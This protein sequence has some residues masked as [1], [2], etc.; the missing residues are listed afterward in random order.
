MQ[1]LAINILLILSSMPVEYVPLMIE[2]KARTEGKRTIPALIKAKFVGDHL[3]R[4]KREGH[5]H[6]EIP[7]TGRKLPAH[8]RSGAWRHQP[9]GKRASP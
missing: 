3:L 2:R 6:G 1:R 5:V 4:A 7:V 8:W 9:H